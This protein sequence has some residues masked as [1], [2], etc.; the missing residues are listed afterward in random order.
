MIWKN[1]PIVRHVL[2]SKPVII[3]ELVLKQAAG[4]NLAEAFGPQNS[5]IKL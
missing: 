2:Q 5:P 1:Q 4:T 3:A